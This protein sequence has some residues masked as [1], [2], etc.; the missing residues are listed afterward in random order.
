[1]MSSG[2]RAAADRRQVEQRALARLCAAP[3]KAPESVSELGSVNNSERRT[4]LLQ[5]H[6]EIWQRSEMM[7][8]LFGAEDELPARASAASLSAAELE[9][10]LRNSQARG[11]SAIQQTREEHEDLLQ[12]FSQQAKEAAAQLDRLKRSSSM[13]EVDQVRSAREAQFAL[14]RWRDAQI[15]TETTPASAEAQQQP[16]P[17]LDPSAYVAL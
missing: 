4:L 2:S 17:A 11:E 3:P 7:H 12:T 10:R 16:R 5:A 15:L 8:E 9:K 14:M 6:H 13:Q 1:M